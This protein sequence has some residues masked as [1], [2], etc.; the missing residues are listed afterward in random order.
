MYKSKWLVTPRTIES[1]VVRLFCFPY[2]GGSATTFIHWVKQLPAKIELNIIQLPGRG[3]RIAEPLVTCLDDVVDS[4]YN[5]LKN[6]LDVP[7]IFF[8]HSFGSRMAFEVT[9]KLYNSNQPTPHYFIA[10]ASR[11][12]S[13]PVSDS[14][15]YDLPEEEFIGR[16]D[17][18]N[19]TPKEILENKEFLD[20]LIPMLRAD[21]KMAETH[22]HQHETKLDIPLIVLGG[23][24]DKS[25]DKDTLLGWTKHFNE[26][27]QLNILE[28]DHFFIETK[29][30][31]II[32][33][34]LPFLN[35]TIESVSN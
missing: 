5:S 24:N 27:V 21:F 18:L 10:S 14:F 6:K 4:I 2:A 20:I 8:G 35:S 25:V 15:S 16:L 17:E 28:G 30:N 1:P 11:P 7:F 12:P 19:G 9:V 34:I 29:S 31:E 32:S 22:V 13:E 23:L 3:S 33:Y 26:T